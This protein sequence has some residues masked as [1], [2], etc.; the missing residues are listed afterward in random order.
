MERDRSYRDRQPV[1]LS[2]H[3]TLLYSHHLELRHWR[4]QT[5]PPSRGRERQVVKVVWFVNNGTV[6]SWRR[7]LTGGRGSCDQLMGAGEV[8]G[9]K[10]VQP[11]LS[12][13]PAHAKIGESNLTNE[14]STSITFIMSSLGCLAGTQL[15]SLLYIISTNRHN[16]L[17]RR[18]IQPITRQ[19]IDWNKSQFKQKSNEIFS[20]ENF[21]RSIVW[22]VL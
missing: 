9:S 14:S 1:R 8:L 2:G 10:A 20:M 17:A 22:Q 18:S 21:V 19:V 7:G 15:A 12:P 13:R 5:L 6:S 16:C 3:H 11:V 4:N